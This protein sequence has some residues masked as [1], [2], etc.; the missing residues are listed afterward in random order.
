MFS[1]PYIQQMS[2]IGDHISKIRTEKKLSLIDVA[3]DTGLTLRQLSDIENAEDI[4]PI[5][6]LLLYL[7]Y[8][9]INFSFN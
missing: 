6:S 3:R 2:A 5:S 1:K 4:Y 9:N 8:L 7:E